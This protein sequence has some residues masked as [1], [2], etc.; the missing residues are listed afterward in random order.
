[1]IYKWLNDFFLFSFQHY[2][3]SVVESFHKLKGWVLI[4]SYSYDK[5]YVA[6]VSSCLA[7]QLWDY[8]D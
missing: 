2:F 4:K 6:N 3:K 5:A 1:M 8:V 7:C